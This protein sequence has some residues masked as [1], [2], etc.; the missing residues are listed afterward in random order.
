MT[1]VISIDRDARTVSRSIYY[2]D[3]KSG[4]Y[5]SLGTKTY[6]IPSDATP[7]SFIAQ[8]NLGLSEEPTGSREKTDKELLE[9]AG[10]LSASE[11]LPTETSTK[12]T[13]GLII[14]TDVNVTKSNT[15]ADKDS[16]MGLWFEGISAS[17]PSNSV[18]GAD[19]PNKVGD[20]FAD[21]TMIS[22]SSAE[23]II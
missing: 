13:N 21:K 9:T 10:L 17:N 14:K 22:W 5:V 11:T 3:D 1:G 2:Y 12:K 15:F 18:A 7:E 6:M 20:V 4:Q 8:L 16:R 19:D 23:K